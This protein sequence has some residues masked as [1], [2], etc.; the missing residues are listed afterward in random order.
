MKTLKIALIALACL[1]IGSMSYATVDIGSSDNAAIIGPNMGPQGLTPVTECIKVSTGSGTSAAIG[2]VMV[3]D[4][5][6][7]SGFA[8]AGDG[9]H[10]K[11]N[12]RSASGGVEFFAGVMVS[13][14][15]QD[16]NYKYSAP[17]ANGPTVGYMAV[18][19]LVRAKMGASCTTGQRVALNGSTLQASFITDG[20]VTVLHRP[21]SQDIGVLLSYDGGSGSLCR[22]WLR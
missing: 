16:S 8:V 7:H 21:I 14:T 22:V 19:G 18:R 5:G 9:Y 2:D 4:T 20:A 1:L 13:A 11:R 10:V 17:K 12:T 3:W 15:S 6:A